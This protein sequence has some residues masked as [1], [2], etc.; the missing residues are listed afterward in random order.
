MSD[1]KSNNQLN[2]AQGMCF[3]ST[4]VIIALQA[5]QQVGTEQE[6]HTF[7][8]AH[9]LLSRP[10]APKKLIIERN[11]WSA[12]P[13]LLDYSVAMNMSVRNFTSNYVAKPSMYQISEG[14]EILPLQ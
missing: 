10:M 7:T 1:L 13:A 9:K 8:C 14:S 11:L 12:L 5:R 2:A 6:I 4:L 3:M